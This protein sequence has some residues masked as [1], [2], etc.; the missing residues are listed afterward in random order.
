MGAFVYDWQHFVLLGGAI[1]GGVLVGIGI[2]K[3]SKIWTVGALFVLIGVVIEPIFTIWLFLYDE[4][5]SRAQQQQ[6]VVATD[7]ASDAAEEL[8]EFLLP[9]N[10]N[11]KEKSRIAKV[12]K[13]YPS[14][15]FMTVTAPE[16]EP[17]GFVMD[18]ATEL[19]SDGWDWIPCPG[20]LQPLD[21]RPSSCASILVGVQINAPENRLD[22]ANALAEAIREP[23]VIGVDNVS[24]VPVPN[25]STIMI[26]VGSKR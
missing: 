24:V 9:R 15:T 13:L 20:G 19:K 18:I 7:R 14:I 1:F 23:D 10:L 6:I 17:W 16:N 3:D 25:A 8:A 2:L 21:A 12:T 4:S 5:I 22:V 26:M 11:N